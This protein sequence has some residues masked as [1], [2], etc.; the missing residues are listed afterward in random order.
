MDMVH[1]KKGSTI[2]KFIKIESSCFRYEAN[3]QHKQT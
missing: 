3:I 2:D 1:D